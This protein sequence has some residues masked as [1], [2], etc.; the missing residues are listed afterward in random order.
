LTLRDR[1]KYKSSKLNY[2][3]ARKQLASLDIENEQSRNSINNLKI[4]QT[5]SDYS[6]K[7]LLQAI[8]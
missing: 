6:V 4:N 1:I 5:K 7:K 3:T 8:V 2:E